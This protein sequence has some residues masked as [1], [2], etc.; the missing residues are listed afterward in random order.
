[1]E[2]NE[3]RSIAR[4]VDVESIINC[5]PKTQEHS[6]EIMS[7]S[8]EANDAIISP[9]KPEGLR[10]VIVK[11]ESYVKGFKQGS[12]AELPIK[13]SERSYDL[14]RL[15][16]LKKFAHMPVLNLNSKEDWKLTLDSIST[17][18]F[19]EKAI[20]VINSA[21]IAN[22]PPQGYNYAFLPVLMPNDQLSSIDSVLS[23]K[24]KTSKN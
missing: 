18:L 2:S 17:C 24:S 22:P 7:S 8:V 19:K 3:T 20:P 14:E 23:S 21:V 11:G 16:N 10:N 1:M 4:D 12:V 9:S 13:Q 6:F 5:I 15:I